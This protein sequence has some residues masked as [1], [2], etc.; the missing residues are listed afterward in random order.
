MKSTLLLT[1]LLSLACA[2]DA[3]AQSF[4]NGSLEAPATTPCNNIYNFQFPTFIPNTGY[5]FGNIIVGG[6]PGKIYLYDATCTEGTAQNG[7]NFLSLSANDAG[8]VDA[9][10]LRLDAPLVAN[11]AYTLTFYTKKS[12]TFPAVGL[13]IGYTTD[14]LAFGTLVGSI[15]APLNATWVKQTINFRPTVSTKFITVRTVKSNTGT[16]FYS[17]EFVDN[18]SIAKGVGV[19]PEAIAFAA[20]PHPNP[21]STRLSFSLSAGVAMPCRVSLSDM[22]GR[23]V[24]EQDASSRDLKIARGNISAGIYLLTVR[25][26][27][28]AASFRR[29]VAE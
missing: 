27:A 12:K 3:D 11:K 5:A 2:G 23:V 10:S 21:F 9:M 28:G 18:F 24:Y 14:S 8:Q 15:E 6:Y 13:E 4:T 29:I 22:T 26:A 16:T 17:Y 19:E 20:D 7:I 1:I 25:D